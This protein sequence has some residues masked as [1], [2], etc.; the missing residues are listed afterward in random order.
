MA[1]ESLVACT[2]CCAA[3]PAAES[4]LLTQ[5]VALSRHDEGAEAG[6]EV[7]QRKLGTPKEG[8]AMFDWFRDNPE[9]ALSP[10][11]VREILAS[12][13][14]DLESARLYAIWTVNLAPLEA[15]DPWKRY[16]RARLKTRVLADVS[17]AGCACFAASTASAPEEE[18]PSI[19]SKAPRQGERAD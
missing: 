12:S 2:Q 13:V 5:A 19:S 17:P 18:A 4:F 7:V 8:N 10:Q 15:Q 1:R 6:L 3:L 11:I 9:R 16:W 14:I